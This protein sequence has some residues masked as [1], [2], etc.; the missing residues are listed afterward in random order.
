M[1]IGFSSVSSVSQVPSVRNSSIYAYGVNWGEPTFCS[2]GFSET[3]Q[4]LETLE[5]LET[6][7]TLNITALK[8][9]KTLETFETLVTFETKPLNT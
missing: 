1:I 5:T 8:T 3:L 4:T 7:Y 9:L 2:G 6:L